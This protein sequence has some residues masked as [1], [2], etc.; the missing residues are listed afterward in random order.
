MNNDFEEE[1]IKELENEG[2][3]AKDREEY[4]KIL[5]KISMSFEM[6]RSESF[7]M[8]FLSKLSDQDKKKRI[9]F[10]APRIYIPALLFTLLLF[11]LIT[12]VV[13]AQKSLPG[14]PLYPIKRLSEN[15][16]KTVNPSFQ[17]EILKRRSEE[18]R[19]LA[20]Q[21]NNSELLKKTLNDY[22]NELKNKN[23]TNSIKIEESKKNL[24]DARERTGENSKEEIESV[25]KK[26][27]DRIIETHNEEQEK[28][29]EDK[30][31]EEVKSAQTSIHEEDKKEG[32]KQNENKKYDD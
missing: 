19:N 29:D 4:T 8:S 3:F 14:Q 25:I 1:L 6:K 23:N 26:T 7:K 10:T 9:F 2:V 13:N 21:K 16:V 12:E 20:Q 22:E 31:I 5:N 30:T 28:E 15:I 24:E 27:E 32:K 17:S 11:I 18:I